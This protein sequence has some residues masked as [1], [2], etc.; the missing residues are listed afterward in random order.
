MV[1]KLLIANWK[2]YLSASEAAELVKKMPLG[3]NIIIAPSLT[4]LALARTIVP[5]TNLAAQDLSALSTEYG[6]YT[7]ETVAAEL[8]DMSV[9]YALI[10]HSERRSNA[11]DNATSI[12]KKAANA[13]DAR[14]TPII[15]VGESKEERKNMQYREAISKQL[16]CLDLKT[17]LDIIIAYEPTWSVGTGALPSRDEIEEIMNLIRSTL[18]IAGKLILVYG[19]SVNAENARDIS[20][21]PGVDG[22]LIGKASTDPQ[23]FNA[24]LNAV[25]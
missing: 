2:N 4:H 24:I 15:C 5:N 12:A 25:K 17:D 6:A 23:Q 21:I 11:L 19:G 3:E 8:V 1:P 13:L 14:I 7:G 16:L 22:L 18:K 20:N 9:K 10:G